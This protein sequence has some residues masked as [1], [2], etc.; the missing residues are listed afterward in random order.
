[1]TT[2]AAP[3]VR[4]ARWTA[5]CGAPGCLRLIEKGSPITKPPGRPWQHVDCRNP[6]YRS[7]SH[8]NR[9]R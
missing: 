5:V 4:I 1:M 2:A 6:G 3:P 8:R 9:G 7:S